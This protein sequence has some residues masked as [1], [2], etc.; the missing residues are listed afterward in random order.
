MKYLQKITAIAILT[1]T[2]SLAFGQAPPP[3]NNNNPGNPGGNPVGGGAPVGSGL[4]ILTAMAAAYGSQ[5]YK[6]ILNA[7]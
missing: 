7:N 1:L 2:I 5:K 6:K 3:P 4:L